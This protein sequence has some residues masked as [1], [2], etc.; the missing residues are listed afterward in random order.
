MDKNYSR[1]KMIFQT[2]KKKRYTIKTAL[3]PKITQLD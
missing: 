2:L 1:K 3:Y